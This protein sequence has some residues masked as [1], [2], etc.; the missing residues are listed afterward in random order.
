MQ[1]FTRRCRHTFEN[2]H[3]RE[4][5]RERERY[6]VRDPSLYFLI[7]KDPEIVPGNILSWS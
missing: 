1:L 2:T 4:R 5:E 3:K 7:P 6:R